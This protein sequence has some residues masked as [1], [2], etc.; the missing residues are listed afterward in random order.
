MFRALALCQ[1]KS[2]FALMKG[3]CSKCQLSISLWWP[4][5]LINSVDK[6]KIFVFHVPTDTTPQFLQKLTPLFGCSLVCT[7][8]Q[9][10]I[11]CLKYNPYLIQ[12]FIFQDFVLD[13][14]SEDPEKFE[15]ELELFEN[16]RKVCYCL[17]SGLG[18]KKFQFT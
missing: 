4:I 12:P 13:H 10:S 3:L 9:I 14:Y 15:K 11:P 2:G 6:S 7:P 8:S 18:Q 17:Q 5:Y 1:S 16:L